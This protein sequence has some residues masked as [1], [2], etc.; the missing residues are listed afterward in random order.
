MPDGSDLLEV[1][2][3][4]GL[5]EL[6]DAGHIAAEKLLANGGGVFIEKF[7]K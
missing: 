4:F 7:N 5:D 6:E 3:T 1:S 2:C